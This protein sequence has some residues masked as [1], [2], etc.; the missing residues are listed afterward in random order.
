MGHQARQKEIEKQF[1]LGRPPISFDSHGYKTVAVGSELYWSSSWKT[2]PDFLMSYFKHVM[3]S[4]GERRSLP[5]HETNG[6]PCLPGT[7]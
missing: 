2:F 6:I 7:Q 3:E 1:G 5:S 4:N